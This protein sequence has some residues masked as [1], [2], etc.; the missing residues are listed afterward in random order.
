T[1]K[2]SRV[3]IRSRLSLTVRW[4]Q[5]TAAPQ[6]GLLPNRDG[7]SILSPERQPLQH[8]G[9]FLAQ[10]HQVRGIQKQHVGHN[11]ADDGNPEEDGD[12]IRH[13]RVCDSAPAS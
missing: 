2:A 10:K 3:T 4:R 9:E 11:R 8:V 5:S 6:G 12:R 1:P 7:L 13:E